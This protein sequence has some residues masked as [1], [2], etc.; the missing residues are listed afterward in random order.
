MPDYE[1]LLAIGVTL[2]MAGIIARGFAAQSRRDLARRK[3]HRLDARK[4]TEALLNEDLDQ[5]PSW[6]ERNF[7]LLANAILFAGVAITAAAFWLR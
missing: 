1:N 2:I 4:S 5:P 3:Q 6:L 7:G